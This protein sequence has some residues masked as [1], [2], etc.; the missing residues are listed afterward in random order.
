MSE[1]PIYRN[2]EFL[3]VYGLLHAQKKS[4]LKNDLQISKKGLN[5]EYESDIINQKALM[6]NN[7]GEIK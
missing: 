2:E 5:F 4:N 3:Y 6:F 7:N 1:K